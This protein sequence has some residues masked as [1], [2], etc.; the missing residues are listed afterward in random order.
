MALRACCMILR[1]ATTR[2]LDME[3]LAPGGETGVHVF[4]IDGHN[5]LTPHDHLFHE[6]VVVLAGSADHVTVAG[7]QKLRPGDVIVI[8]PQI[9]HGYERPRGLSLINALFDGRL[10]HRFD[11]LLTDVDG[12]LELFGRRTRQPHHEPPT[13]LHTRPAERTPI[14]DRLNAI[15]HEQRQRRT[16][17]TAAVTLGMLDVLLATTRLA[18]HETTLDTPRTRA[19]LSDRTTEAV[20]DCVAHLEA[21]YDE[22]VR[23]D[24]LAAKVHLSPPHLSRAF[25]QRMGMGVVA[26]CHCLRIEEACRLLRLTDEPIGAIASRCGYAEIAYFNRR[27]KQQIGQSPTA[28]RRMIAADRRR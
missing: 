28:Y 9:W 11:K 15:M 1:M 18:Q 5:P 20:L 21:H 16:G 2:T 22:P 4:Q 23:L 6:I 24:E 13:L 14:V 8:R 7:R 12:A 10:I 25:S 3:V 19:A 26:F 27:F 17:W